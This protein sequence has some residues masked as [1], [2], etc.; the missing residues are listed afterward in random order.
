MRIKFEE[1][2]IKEAMPEKDVAAADKVIE[3]LVK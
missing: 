3:E 2:V 1:E